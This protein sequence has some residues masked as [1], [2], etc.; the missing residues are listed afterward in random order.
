MPHPS[1]HRSRAWLVWILIAAVVFAAVGAIVWDRDFR[2]ASSTTPGMTCP[3]VVQPTGHVPLAAIGVHRVALIGD[4]IMDQASCAIATSLA[5]VGLQTGRYAVG[6]SGLLTGFVDWPSRTEQIL[7]FQHPDIVVAIFVG[8]YIG[9]SAKNAQGQPIKDNSPDFFAAWQA[10]AE[11]I[12]AEVHAAGAQM[13][14]ISPPPIALP[15]LNHAQQLFDGYRTIPGDHVLLSGSVLA[16]PNGQEVMTKSTCGRQQ[17]VRSPVDAT[18]LTDVGAR[19]YG[20]Q[21]AHDLTAQLG[22]LTAPKPC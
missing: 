1:A 4:S 5:R 13:Y 22:I 10:R 15:P 18:H 11:Q 2:K 16:G 9:R 7:K 17:V 20:E 12:S 8:N 14:W 21:I 6:G 3:R 19:I